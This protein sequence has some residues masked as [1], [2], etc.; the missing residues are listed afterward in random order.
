MALY[1]PANERIISKCY[2]VCNFKIYQK[3]Y[4][5]LKCSIST[6]ICVNYVLT[7]QVLE[8]PSSVYMY[9][10]CTYIYIVI[11][12]GGVF[13]PFDTL[14]IHLVYKDTI[15]QLAYKYKEL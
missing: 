9:E 1:L 13:A 11:E 10:L 15:K 14:F 6:F 8:F 4:V 7:I 2:Y 5:N 12:L 3:I